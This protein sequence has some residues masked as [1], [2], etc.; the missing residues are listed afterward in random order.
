MSTLLIFRQLLVKY[1]VTIVS[2]V[3]MTMPLM[4]IGTVYAQPGGRAQGG[5]R[6]QPPPMVDQVPEYEEAMVAP[7]AAPTPQV[8]NAQVVVTQQPGGNVVTTT[9]SGDDVAVVV[10]APS[11]QGGQGQPQPVQRLQATP[12]QVDGVQMQRVQI[13]SGQ[14]VQ[15]FQPGQ[16]GP[17]Q[18]FQPGQGRPGQGGQG[19]GGQGQVQ[20]WQPGQNQGGPGQGGQGNRQ[21]QGGQA[22][23]SGQNNRNQPQQPVLPRNRQT[24]NTPIEDLVDKDFEDFMTTGENKR[25]QFGFKG[26]P[27]RTVIQWF[28]RES[29]LTLELETAP[30]GSF[31][32]HD[33]TGR[34][35]SIDETFSLLNSYL[36]RRNFLLFR[37]AQLLMLV[38]LADGIPTE[39]IR[40]V[41][42]DKLDDVGDYEVVRVLFSLTG[43]T[44]DVVQAEIQQFLGPQGLIVTLPKSQQIY[45]TEFG[46]KLRTIREIIRG[47][48]DPSVSQVFERYILK[49]LASDMALAQ[50]KQLLPLS[51]ND[52]TLRAMIDP[53]GQLIML[54]GRIDRVNAAMRLLGMIDVESDPTDVFFRVYS[55][56]SASPQLVL[57]V[58]QTRLAGRPDVRLELDTTIGALAVQGR[59]KDHEE[60]AEIIE[61]LE[62]V[63][64]TIEVLH[65]KRL[66]TTAA[67]DAID[68][69]FTPPTTTQQRPGGFGV[70]GGTTNTATVA[71]PI[72]QTAPTLKQLIVKG[73]KSQITQIKMLLTQMGE[74]NLMEGAATPRNLVDNGHVPMS[75]KEA[76]YVFQMV[77]Q[78]WSQMGRGQINVMS[79]GQRTSPLP[80]NRTMPYQFNNTSP[81]QQPGVPFE[82]Q[83]SVNQQ[84]QLLNDL[85]YQVHVVDGGDDNT[86]RNVPLPQQMPTQYNMMTPAPGYQQQPAPLQFNIPNNMMP[87]PGFS[88]PVNTSSSIPSQ[89]DGLLDSLFGPMEPIPQLPATLPAAVPA[90]MPANVPAYVPSNAVPVVQPNVPAV[91]R[92]TTQTSHISELVGHYLPVAYRQVQP[93]APPEMQEPVTEPADA[94]YVTEIVAFDDMAD[95]PEPSD[96]Y[97]S[98]IYVSNSGIQSQVF[99]IVPD[100]EADSAV[101]G[102][103]Q[104]LSQ[105]FQRQPVRETATA[106]P[107]AQPPVTDAGQPA[108][109][110]EQRAG[111]REQGT[112][113]REQWADGTQPVM[114]PRGMQPPRGMPQDMRPM[115]P[116][117]N[118]PQNNAPQTGLSVSTGPSGVVATGNPDDVADFIEL[119][120]MFANE[121]LLK[122]QSTQF[123]LI[124]NAK[125]DTIKTMLTSLLGSYSTTS[126]A[127]DPLGGIPND[128]MQ[129]MVQ[130][131]IGGSKIQATGS[132]E[133]IV[134]ARSNM[135]IINANPVDHLTIQELLPVLD[136]LGRSD[137]VMINSKP[138]MIKLE[139]M[140]AEDA[141][142]MVRTLFAENLQGANRGG[143][144]AAGGARPG[145]QGAQQN[146]IQMLMAQGGGPPGMMQNPMLQQMMQ[147][148]GGNQQQQQEVQ[149]MT[150]AVEKTTN[151]L[152]VYSPEELYLDVKSFVEDLDFAAQSQEPTTGMVH[153]GN[154]SPDFYSKMIRS[155]L[156]TSA[157]V[158][159]QSS[160]G[161]GGRTGGGGGGNMGGGA[162]PGG[163]GGMTFP[164]G[165][166]MTFPGGGGGGG[167]PGGGARP[168]GGGA[169]GFGGIQVGRGG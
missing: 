131:M 30:P 7:A 6:G 166:G 36:I 74:P 133:I 86:Q 5:M 120:Q 122:A 126:S 53:T 14:D 132:Y 84:I 163:A 66:T 164:G 136:R 100:I 55:I 128:P 81:G 38:N 80:G 59:A 45:V 78:V 9:T 108:Q 56:P 23:Q 65:L 139:Y 143:G 112:D 31:S 94:E 68:N 158:S 137:D 145:Q 50:L 70:T 123:Y 47:I 90:T 34:D 46:D 155:M 4:I 39:L 13:E 95:T 82:A 20:Q 15:N 89:V 25:L 16:G 141:E 107:L 24:D 156:G 167:Q 8:R 96:D 106:Q 105:R 110:V 119:V 113:L 58:A 18:G 12:V 130:N 51:D 62:L 134:D 35:Y 64:F 142:T 114:P 49:S 41:P 11:P 115:P 161:G 92:L 124:K 33:E 160:V 151:S 63:A 57:K 42:L 2:V 75:E 138:H 149:T 85:G 140:K 19:Q 71:A 103:S 93:T 60:V 44:P 117:Q 79:P 154:N 61:E 98:D 88:Q 159:N 83:E 43:T 157:T 99:G 76:V 127:S 111:S 104:F 169:G 162:R 37:N 150:L 148:R 3:L 101:S 48:D 28:A 125:A 52:T 135:L 22:G 17:G 116:G 73:T 27:W 72:V 54:S 129:A 77:E 102:N 29:G 146:P 147:Q 1:R 26:T 40:D 144:G 10:T 118:N 32:Y 97:V 69:Y 87:A 91:N 152:I 21:P 153:V 168:G 165:G 67:K 109:F 121:G